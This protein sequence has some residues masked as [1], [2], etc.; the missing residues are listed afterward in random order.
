LAVLAAEVYLDSVLLFSYQAV[1][2]PRLPHI[3]SLASAAPFCT[4]GLYLQLRA[5]ACHITAWSFVYSVRYV[6]ILSTPC[7]L[8]LLAHASAR[9][10]CTHASYYQDLL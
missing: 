8:P 4:S 6:Y 7:A 1:C 3:P 10:Q 5:A 9:L 2:C